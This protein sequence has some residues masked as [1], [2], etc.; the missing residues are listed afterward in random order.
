MDD[1]FKRS[2]TLLELLLA[3]SM[4]G[5]LILGISSL[6]NFAQFH[7][8]SFDRRT[9]I[10]NESSY[11]LEHMAKNI[12][13]GI[14]SFNNLGVVEHSTEEWIK[15]RLDRNS[16]GI[17]DD[18]GVTDWIAYRYI[19]AQNEIQYHANYDAS[20][21]PTTGGETITRKITD[22]NCSVT[23]GDNYIFSD[24]TA[25]WDPDGVPYNCGTIDNPQVKMQ[26]RIKMPAVSVN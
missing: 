11:V 20:S 17:P 7:L 26:A 23:S 6:T 2:V 14:G 25:C 12:S 21:W 15:V 4:V 24:V 19:P 10:Q 8:I 9:Q 13:Q 1:F 3:S 18:D 5:L 22:F 16:N